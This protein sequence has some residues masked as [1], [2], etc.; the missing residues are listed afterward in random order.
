MSEMTREDDGEQPHVET[1]SSPE[2]DY[3]MRSLGEDVKLSNSPRR[4]GLKK[5]AAKP[6]KSPSSL[7]VSPPPRDNSTFFQP[8]Q[9]Q[10]QSHPSPP[11]Q[12]DVA[13]FMP[14]PTAPWI[15]FP[16][17]LLSPQPVDTHGLNLPNTTI[18]NPTPHQSVQLTASP[19]DHL[20][21][22]NSDLLEPSPEY[23][24]FPASQDA[25][26]ATPNFTPLVQLLNLSPVATKVGERTLPTLSTYSDGMVSM[27]ASSRISSEAVGN[28]DGFTGQGR[29]PSPTPS[30]V[31]DVSPLNSPLTSTPNSPFDSPFDSPFGSEGGYFSDGGTLI[32]IVGVL[33]SNTS[34]AKRK[35]PDRALDESEDI[36]PLDEPDPKKQ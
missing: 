28:Q 27:P 7:T 15:K 29:L 12:F 4:P 9:Q 18:G 21:T 33:E 36:Q 26:P 19:F 14:S 24:W 34:S 16:P 3:L 1:N 25:Q 32:D 23:P 17:L 10:Q 11:P 20:S 30:L 6:A 5:R 31:G 8:Q 2:I 35:T 22:S 13:I